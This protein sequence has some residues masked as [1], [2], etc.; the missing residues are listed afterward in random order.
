MTDHDP[1]CPD[2]LNGHLKPERCELCGL[3]RRVRADERERIAQ[4]IEAMDAAAHTD[5]GDDDQSSQ[6]R[7]DCQRGA[8]MG[9]EHDPLCWMRAGGLSCICA[10]LRS[11]RADERER[12]AGRRR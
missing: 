12:I 8:L 9:E 1:L 3:L 11:A 10:D 5:W 2:H 6:R 7:S 4:A